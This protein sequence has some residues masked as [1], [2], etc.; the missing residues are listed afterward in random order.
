[1]HIKNLAEIT[2]TL[3]MV[4]LK[5]EKIFY[6]VLEDFLDKSIFSVDLTYTVSRV[7]WSKSVVKIL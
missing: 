3:Y 6:Q 4:S 5:P 1:M 7:Y 2:P